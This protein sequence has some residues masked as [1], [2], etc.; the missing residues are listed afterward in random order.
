[1][2]MNEPSQREDLSAAQLFRDHAAF[3]ARLLYRLGVSA[4]AIEDTVQ[5]VFLVVH[6]RGGYRPGPAKPTTYLSV[7]ASHVASTERRR[8]RRRAARVSNT[9]LEEIHAPDDDPALRVERRDEL[10]RLQAALSRLDPAL[11][12]TL[13]LADFEDETAPAIAHAMGVPVGT[14]YWR[15]HQAR[16]KFQRALS[17]AD[18]NQER[19]AGKRLANGRLDSRELSRAA[20]LWAI[21]GVLTGSEYEAEA[22]ELAL[23]WREATV[24]FDL[25]RGLQRHFERV[26]AAPSPCAVLSS[27]APKLSLGAGAGTLQLGAWSAVAAGGVL[28]TLALLWRAAGDAPDGDTVEPVRV[29]QA[30]EAARQGS[31][32]APTASPAAVADAIST[33][34]AQRDAN[35]IPA[36]SL[37]LE[38]ASLEQTRA[39]NGSR[40]T[41]RNTAR[42]VSAGEQ[43]GRRPDVERSPA[44]TVGEPARAA[45]D[46]RPGLARAPTAQ[47]AQPAPPNPAPADNFD[48]LREARA[49]KRADRLLTTDPAQA[50]A[51]VR[52]LSR[53][54]P[55]EYLSEERRYIEIMALYGVGRHADADR[56]ADHFL[57]RYSSSAFRER[58][59][60]ARTGAASG[61]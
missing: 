25:A 20:K 38:A 3:I 46:D 18:G 47:P 32:A 24:D 35:D 21:V 5:D 53:A 56:A 61:H 8:Q 17:I 54:L 41:P 30:G 14:V 15:L 27:A 49:L 45:S 28:A 39:R 37:E 7:I 9:P 29:A 34:T 1:M 60:A 36:E 52:E 42:D 59:Q 48:P 23:A 13:L 16:K 2:T 55:R 33:T 10:H 12:D 58:V 44:P 50:L 11:R 40:K 4:E 57:S 19:A 43:F 6:Q 51:I 31:L 22:R 26:G